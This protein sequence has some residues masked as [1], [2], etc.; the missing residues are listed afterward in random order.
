MMGKQPPRQSKLFYTG[1][2]LEKRIRSNHPLRRIRKAIDFEFIYDE[3]E[4]KYGRN[5]NVSVPPP[6]ILKLMLLLVFYNVRSERELMDTL[7]ER[8]DWLWFLGYDLDADIPD[9]SVL[10]KARR[11]WGPDVFERFF[12]RIVRQCVEARMVDGR[13]LFIDSSLVEADASLD[14]VI[15]PA[16]LRTQL[17]KRYHLL[18][19]RLEEAPSARKPGPEAKANRR[20]T[21]ATDPDASVINR[22]TTKLRYQVHRA[23]EGQSEIITATETTPGEVS[24]AHLMLDL[25]EEHLRLTGIQA[26]TVVA[27]SKYGTKE[28]YLACLDAGIKAH[29]PAF[30]GGTR[31]RLKNRGL[32][33]EDQFHYDPSRDI[34]V[35][36]AGQELKRKTYHKRRQ[37][38][39]Y[40][41]SKK[42]CASCE[43]RERCTRNKM[44]RTITRHERQE[45]LGK[46]HQKTTK[47]ECRSDLRL[48]QHLGER[49]FA[50]ATRYGY[51]RARWR[52]LWRVQIQD[53]L[54]CT[55][56]NIQK[57]VNH[58]ERRSKW[59][60]EIV[61]GV[62]MSIIAPLGVQ[63]A[64]LRALWDLLA[65]SCSAR[66][67]GWSIDLPCEL[68]VEI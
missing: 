31:K 64:L 14:S 57:L 40:A 27:D 52:R 48:R 7:P 13:K 33:L 17:S 8:L 16:D 59:A 32:Y 21:S 24:E 3:V 46:M 26:D 29:V 63:S 60:M 15:D 43:E 6:V 23:V 36:P 18:E 51:K 42:V 54:I 37:S 12:Q 53:Y 58:R 61:A 38:Y 41:A 49:S 39:D 4:E 1:L 20:K 62:E 10:S 30:K 35:C 22:G 67:A 65:A 56:Q 45:D 5:G 9:H 11:R 68:V 25:L 2:N 34:Y 55:V 44:G 28:N 50:T 47:A 19:E 66:G